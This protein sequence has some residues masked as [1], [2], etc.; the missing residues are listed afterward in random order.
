MMT[1]HAPQLSITPESPLLC[2]CGNGGDMGRT[3]SIPIGITSFVTFGIPWQIALCDVTN[4]VI[5]SRKCYCPHVTFPFDVAIPPPLLPA[6]TRVDIA[7]ADFQTGSC[8]VS[9]EAGGVH[10]FFSKVID[11]RAQSWQ[12]QIAATPWDATQGNEQSPGFRNPT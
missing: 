2:P 1:T 4:F 6:F 12:R 11:R 7:T 3:T 8:R 5:Y 10:R 9:L